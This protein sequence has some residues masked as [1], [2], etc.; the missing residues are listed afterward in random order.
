MQPSS[1]GSQMLDAIIGFLSSLFK[2]WDSMPDEHKE[3]IKKAAGK[4]F[5]TL[6]SRYY[7]EQTGDQA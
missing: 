5:D 1:P 6:F 7:D 3:P 2:F 4:A